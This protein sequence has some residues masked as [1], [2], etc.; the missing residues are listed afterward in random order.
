VSAL[1][2]A[3]PNH[4]AATAAVAALMANGVP[5]DRLRVLMGAPLHDVRQEQVG[6]FAG[7]IGPDAPVGSFG[8]VPHRRSEPKGDFASSGRAG[9][10]GTFA[11]ADRDTVTDHPDGVGR[12]H[13]TGDHDVEQILAD[14]GLDVDAARRDVRALHEGWALVLVREPHDAERV[15]RVLDDA[16]LSQ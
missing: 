3:Y 11:D 9:R 12:I 5:G 14:A 1:C 10:V 16:A 2:K 7:S 4:D 15:Q 8:D 13:V 6:E